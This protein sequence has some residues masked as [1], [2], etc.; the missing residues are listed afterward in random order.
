MADPVVEVVEDFPDA[1]PVRPVWHYED[2]NFRRLY[3]REFELHQQTQIKLQAALDEIQYLKQKVEKLEADNLCLRK[4]LFSKK[5]EQSKSVF[6]NPSETQEAFKTHGA[7]KG[8]PGYGRKIPFHLLQQDRRHILAEEDCYCERCGAPFKEL[9]TEEISYEVTVETRRYVLFRHRRQKYRKSC[10]CPHPIVTSPGPVKLFEQGLYSMDF[11]I[12]V[13]LDK[14]AYAMPLERQTVKMAGEGLE[15]SSGVLAAGLLRM[16]P[17]LKPL[18]ELMLERIAFEPLVHADET[19]WQNWAS[20]Y[21]E[22]RKTEKSRHWLWGLFSSRYHVFIIDPSRGAK[23]IRDKLGQGPE[24]TI[25]PGFVCDRYKAYHALRTTLAFCW[26]H[27]RRDFLKLQA[28]YRGDEALVGWAQKEI[29]LIGEMYALNRLRLGHQDKPAIWE[30]YENQ[31][32]D[33]LGRMQGLMKQPDLKN[34][35]KAVAESLKNHW[36]GLTRFLD[37]PAIALDNNLAEREL[38]TPVVGRKNFYGTHSDRATE[39][40]AIFYSILSTCKRHGIPT[41]KFLKRYLTAYVQRRDRASPPTAQWL[42]SFLPE[43][44]AKLFPQDLATC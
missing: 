42:E 2:Q 27:V 44:Y 25:L 15:I 17:Y 30:G 33:V 38:R 20:S 11:W 12:Q 35:Q 26:A 5:T 14:Y 6:E 43:A 41:Q 29:D 19:R 34:S 21:E 3:E 13:L 18:Y 1:L 28:Q 36:E 24:K 37:N 32:R 22:E 4:L 31:I 8:H 7:Q 16:A 10:Q 9:N 39:A 23:V 40:T